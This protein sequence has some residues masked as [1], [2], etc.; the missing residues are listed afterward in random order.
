MSRA[1]NAIVSA[2]VLLLGRGRRRPSPDERR[3]VPALPPNPAAELAVL[4]LLG[5]SSLSALGFILIY[6][7]A[8]SL[9]RGFHARAIHRRIGQA[10][11]PASSPRI[12][13]QRLSE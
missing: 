7:F 6:A 10:R 9:P 12:S 5:L 11:N 13:E 3:I 8:G 2:L 4:A 1:R